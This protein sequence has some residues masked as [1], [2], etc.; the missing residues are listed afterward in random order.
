MKET[1][2]AEPFLKLEKELDVYRKLMSQAADVIREKDVS[3]YP[4]FVVHQQEMEIGMVLYDSKKQGGVWNV[5]ASTLEEFVSKQII[6]PDKIDEFKSN[7]KNVE[8]YVCV[9]VLSELGAQFV[10][11]PRKVD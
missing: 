8:A 10:F 9:F 4:I 5:H 6:H 11:L 3:E 7:Y 1:K 2:K